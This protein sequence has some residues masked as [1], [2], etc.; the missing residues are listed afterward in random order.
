ME[1]LK[2]KVAKLEVEH[3]KLKVEMEALGDRMGVLEPFARA[4]AAKKKKDAL[5][6]EARNMQKTAREAA[7]SVKLRNLDCCCLEPKGK[8]AMF[9]RDPRLDE[10]IPA[11]AAK[12]VEFGKKIGQPSF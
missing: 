6:L 9:G 7:K 11:W 5:N 8:G 10:H 2:Q 4:F 3:A 1:A 12:C